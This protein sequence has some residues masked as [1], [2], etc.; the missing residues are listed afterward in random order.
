MKR[1]LLIIFVF[2]FIYM[3]LFNLPFNILHILAIISYLFILN[4]YYYITRS[5]LNHNGLKIFILYHILSILFVLFLF[6]FFS[7]S[8]LISYR[9]F[10]IVF[11][12]IPISIFISLQL[13]K[14]KFNLYDFY[15]FI[16]LIGVIQVGFVLLTFIFPSIRYLLIEKYASGGLASNFSVFSNFR[17]FGLSRGYM[18]SMPLFQ[19]LCII[20][21][22]ILGTFK[23]KK[24]FL[25]IP[26]YIFSISLNARIGLVSILAVLA[27]LLLFKQKGTFFKQIIGVF[28]ISVSFYLFIYFVQTKAENS[29]SMNTWFWLNKGFTQLANIREE[30]SFG[31]IHNMSNMWF[32]PDFEYFIFGT[33]VVPYRRPNDLNS[34][35]GYVQIFYYGGI[36]YSL[37]VYMAY[38]TITKRLMK[39]SRPEEKIL[40]VSI[41]LYLLLANVKGL[42][43][44][45]AEHTHG[46][47]LIYVF[48]IITNKIN[49]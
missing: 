28:I 38:I 10:L 31:I 16:L 46:I 43:F 12:V 44:S 5:I 4:K 30:Q 21:S 48:S 13:I 27:T 15:N 36:I 41:L 11:E 33:G 22:T 40:Y 1:F 9:H 37:L 25:L 35:V 42:S 19:G 18:Y 23:S 32:V 3:P 45:S 20:I 7:G 26:L 14:L 8:I 17:A 6:L 49:S 34:D 2:L 47:I 39:F 24:Y 29:T